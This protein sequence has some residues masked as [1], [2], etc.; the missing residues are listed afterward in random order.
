[1]LTR[2]LSPAAE[3]PGPVKMK[4]CTLISLLVA[5]GDGGL[6]GSDFISGFD[7]AQP[8]SQGREGKC[9]HCLHPEV[10]HECQPSPSLIP[11]SPS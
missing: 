1:M 5:F 6:P 4:S 10:S 2:A 7:M 3:S 8:K 11:Q 9:R